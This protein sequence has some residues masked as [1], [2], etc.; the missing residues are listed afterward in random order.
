MVKDFSSAQIPGSHA[1]SF[2]LAVGRTELD[3]AL[4]TATA[5]TILPH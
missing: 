1:I 4:N 5:P 3:K 2:G